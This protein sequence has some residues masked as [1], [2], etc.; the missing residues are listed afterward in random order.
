MAALK[1]ELGDLLLQVV[2]HAR[3]AE[4]QRRLRLRRRGR[5]HHR[6]DDPPPPA[7]VRQRGRARGRRRARL[8]GAHQGAR[9]APH[10]LQ[11]GSASRAQ[12]SWT[13]F[14]PGF[15]R[16]RAPSSCR[17]KPPGSA[18][19]GRRSAPVFDKLKEELGELE[20][21]LVGGGSGVRPRRRS[22]RSSATC[23]SWSPTSPGTSKSIPKRRC[24]QPTRNSS[25]ASMRSS[26][27][28]RGRAHARAIDAGRDGPALGP[29]QSRR[30]GSLESASID[31][32]IRCPQRSV[33]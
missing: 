2:Y 14:L 10:A 7:R 6:K 28:W 25:A 23:C 15:R 27:S 22:R 1:D 12:A 20:D 8:L 11:A 3:M 13:T 16:S 24:A 33:P 29:S 30:K 4:E 9:S 19:T 26:A 5:R 32:N 18:S 31:S 21:V 17:T